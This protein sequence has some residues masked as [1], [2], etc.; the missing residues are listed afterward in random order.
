M[1]GDHSGERLRVLFFVAEYDRLNGAQ[2]S[3]LQLVRRLPSF[4]VDPVV[5]FPGEGLCSRAYAEAGV[6]VEILP[7][8]R[9]L[10]E[11]GQHLL[12]GSLV[13]KL[14]VLCRDILPYSWKV[15]RLMRRLGCRIL[16]CNTTRSL[17]LGAPAA[18]LQRYRV[19]WHVRGQLQPFS[20]AIKKVSGVLSSG[21]IL[22]AE[23]LR[24]EVPAAFRAKCRTIYNGIDESAFPVAS[25]T[26]SAG[27]GFAAAEGAPVI[28]TFAAL[29]PFKGYHH[30]VRAA[31]AVTRRW[32]G[33]SPV[34]LAIGQ[35]FDEEYREFLDRCVDEQGLDNFHFLGWQNDPLPYYRRADLVVLPTVHQ[36][37]LQINGKLVQVRS[38]EG[39]PRTVLEA[40]YLGKPVVAT[41]VAGA[42]EQVVEGET[43][44]LVPP[45]DAEAM[46]DAILRVL[47]AP[48]ERRRAM[49]EQA[50]RR[51]RTLFSTN[52]MTEQTAHLYQELLAR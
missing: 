25:S 33:P 2:R 23:S 4:G 30:L 12:A 50:A 7:A 16:H 27:N 6:R 31:A 26:A 24:D 20:S 19:V 44:Y 11:F 32:Q 39:F 51:A 46:A 17:L 13:N 1:N 47:D 28:A 14:H 36:E 22:V 29:T 38:G 34:F 9:R 49:G 10:R 8:P 15:T 42:P 52:R 41:A 18:Y 43:G 35:P 45:G 3:L 40:M 37:D 5:V 48:A 21:I